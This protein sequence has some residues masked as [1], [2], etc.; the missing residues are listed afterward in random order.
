MLMMGCP[1]S[2]KG[3]LSA[4]LERQLGV[5]VL[6][7]GDM[8][9]W[10]VRHGTEVGRE[11][12]RVIRT[13]SL[14]P[15]TTMMRLIGPE[16]LKRRD[17]DW[18][19][20]GFPRTDAQAQRLHEFLED[21]HMP[22]T[23][24]V[25]LIVPEDVILQR[26]LDRWTHMP[27]GRV[28]NLSFNPPKRAG[29]DDVTGEPLEKRDDDNPATFKRRIDS[30]HS[31]TEPMI[32]RFRKLACP[33]DPSRPLLVPLAGATSD[34]IWPKLQALIFERFPYMATRT[35]SCPGDAGGAADPSSASTTA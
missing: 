21:A 10:H 13:G 19:L 24:I 35:T 2:G 12:D 8:L 18:I 33:I 25:H 3:T 17:S 28:Y 31:L 32:E 34:E 15:D 22:L 23:L 16:L 20:D 30:Y 27:S 9:R 11:A 26:I 5:P 6:T 4:R 1:G 14:M 29:L 7:A